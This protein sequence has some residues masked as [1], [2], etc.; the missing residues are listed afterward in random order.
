MY[1]HRHPVVQKVLIGAFVWGM[2][3]FS[4]KVAYG[5]MQLPDMGVKTSA[6]PNFTFP[7]DMSLP[8]KIPMPT[9]LPPQPVVVP[10][11]QACGQT[12]VDA[13]AACTAQ[14]GNDQDAIHLCGVALNDCNTACMA[15]DSAEKAQ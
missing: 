2:M 11:V 14:A 4:M 5:Q 13:A 9:T 7:S 10:T 3:L 1:S 6:L 8:S 15:V 12:C